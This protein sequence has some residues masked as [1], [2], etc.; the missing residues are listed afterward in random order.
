[1]AQ[2]VITLKIM[3]ESPETDLKKIEI[4]AT[5]AIT[6]FGGHVGKVEIEPVAFGL[7]AVKLLG[8][9]LLLIRWC[10]IMLLFL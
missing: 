9:M 8:R 6:A 2:V 10:R 7:K 5:E 3:P 4:K 1:M